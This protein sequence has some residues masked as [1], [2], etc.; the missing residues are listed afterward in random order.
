MSDPLPQLDFESSMS[1]ADPYSVLRSNSQKQKKRARGL[2]VATGN[3]N[4]RGARSAPA[5]M[6]LQTKTL[7]EHLNFRH[8]GHAPT[9][10]NTTP[11]LRQQLHELKMGSTRALPQV[12]SHKKVQERK[13]LAHTLQV[14]QRMNKL[15]GGAQDRGVITK[16]RK[17]NKTLNKQLRTANDEVALAKA[18]ILELR[19]QLQQLRSGG[20][21]CMDLPVL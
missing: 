6:K 3:N 16:L 10:P 2:K 13:R 9:M 12:E 20:E 17:E 21:L 15:L 5:S 19:E 8:L 18:E 11:S 14:K 1:D 7:I 4:V